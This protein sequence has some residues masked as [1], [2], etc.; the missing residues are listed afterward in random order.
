MHSKYTSLVQI[1]IELWSF[2]LIDQLLPISGLLKENIYNAN[3][4]LARYNACLV[5]RRFSQVVGID[6]TEIFSP[7]VNLHGIPRDHDFLCCPL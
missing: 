5:A 7:I 3:G 6:Y 2:H 1:K 4:T